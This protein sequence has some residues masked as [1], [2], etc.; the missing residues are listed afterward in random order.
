M[1]VGS[2]SFL[3]GGRSFQECRPEKPELRSCP[4]SKK[5]SG[6]ACAHHVDLV[7][8][9]A[10]HHLLHRDAVLVLDR[11]EDGDLAQRGPRQP[12]LLPDAS[13]LLFLSRA[14]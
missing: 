11:E 12:L 5:A 14:S 7:H 8:A 6:R 9:G 4:A 10:D 3:L 2:S 1:S 13:N